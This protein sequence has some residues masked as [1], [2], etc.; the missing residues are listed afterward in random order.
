[1]N[2]SRNSHMRAPRSV[3]AAPISCPCRRPKLAMDFFAF[4][5][6]GCWPVIVAS[7]S[8][9]LSSTFG[10][11]IASPTPTFT[12]IF[13]SV[14]TWC[15]FV[16]PNCCISFARICS[17]YTP[18]R[19]GGGTGMCAPACGPRACASPPPLRCFFSPPPP[20]CL[21]APFA[22][23]P[24]FLLSFVAIVL[25]SR[26]AKLFSHRFRNRF[27]ALDA[28]AFLR[29]ILVEAHARPRRIAALRIDQ[30]HVGDVNRRLHL[31]DPALLLGRARLAVLL[32]DVHAL[33]DDATLLRVDAD[34]FPALPLVVAA[35]DLHLVAAHDG[36]R[37]PLAIVGVPLPV[38]GARPVR[39][40]KLEN[41]HIR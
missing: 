18:R 13:S 20:C 10:C 25:S 38:D 24:P 41:S 16:R 15:G 30:H 33:H 7:S 36:H 14:G 5:R 3:T 31:D 9:T 40:A 8:T 27:A 26:H 32:H 39:P 11:L 22:G 28:D 23:V 1:M 29:A 21:G 17:W 37:H 19:R 35:H 4:F 34:H 2:R 6:T 12:T